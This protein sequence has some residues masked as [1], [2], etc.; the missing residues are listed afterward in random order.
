[1]IWANVN[2]AA[3][4]A[5]VAYDSYAVAPRQLT[6]IVEDLGY[7]APRWVARQDMGEAPPGS[8]HVPSPVWPALAGLA[9]GTMLVSLYLVLVTVAQDW[10]HATEL[11]WGD[12]WLVAAIAAGF[13]VQIGLYVHL[14]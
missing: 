1:M 4:Q 14:R 12:R 8:S 10:K 5:V 7:E 3:Q 9:A 2:F 13:G 6:E 11:L